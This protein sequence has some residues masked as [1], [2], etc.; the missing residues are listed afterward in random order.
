MLEEIRLLS[1]LESASEKL[2]QIVL[3]GHSELEST[4]R[5]PDLR[6]LRQRISIWCRTSPLTESQ[7]EAYVAERLR[8]AGAR[9]P[10]M[11][12]EAVRLVHHYSN[13][14][15]RVINLICEHALVEAFADQRKLVAAETVESVAIEL[16]CDESSVSAVA[17]D[18]LLPPEGRFPAIIRRTIAPSTRARLSAG[19][20][21]YEPS[22]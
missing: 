20:E 13:G 8:I 7:S 1:N 17:S 2:L 6:Q 11:S 15:P 3:C 14:I 10:V 5:S 21:N 4:L 12:G 18:R 9:G 16:D 22:I 19:R